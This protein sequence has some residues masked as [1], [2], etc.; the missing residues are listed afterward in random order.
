MPTYT[1]M[2][3][4]KRRA[5]ARKIRAMLGLEEYTIAQIMERKSLSRAT[6]YRI[7]QE[8]EA[9]ENSHT[10]E[11]EAAEINAMYPEYN[12]I[13]WCLCSGRLTLAYARGELPNGNAL[14]NGTHREAPIG[15]CDDMD[16][17]DP[18]LD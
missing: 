8:L 16:E 7:M 13:K 4:V 15:L 3:A 11:D 12:S 9:W 5:Q 2:D 1:P 6:I 10:F 18:L 17:P 14:M